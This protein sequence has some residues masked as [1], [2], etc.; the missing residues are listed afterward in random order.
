MPGWNDFYEAIVGASA[1]LTGLIFVGV[2]ISLTKILSIRGLPD[3][4]LL[5][6]VLLLN[7]LVLS[8][9]F[10]APDLSM[11]TLG[12]WVIVIGISA[13]LIVFGLDLIIYR[14]KQKEYK[15]LHL[16][17]MLIDQMATICFV[18]AG[19]GI[20]SGWANG[21]YWVV[22]AIIVSIV[23]AVVDGWVLLVEINR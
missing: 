21:E 7:V 10:L 9:L 8:I 19:I 14:S 16:L 6:L 5:S 22:P 13:W 20:T 1:A 2:S 12:I 11:K 17:N 4:A 3:R 15:K 18:L 23:K